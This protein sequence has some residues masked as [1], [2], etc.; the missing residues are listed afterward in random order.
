MRKPK[1]K[2]DKST[3]RRNKVSTSKRKISID[4][5]EITP[6]VKSLVGVI[7]LPKNYDY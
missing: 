3:N 7:K 2:I 1:I 4:E 5:V 6:I